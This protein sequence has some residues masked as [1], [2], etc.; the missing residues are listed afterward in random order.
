MMGQG[1]M[2]P[3]PGC[4]SLICRIALFG[5][6]ALLA[7]PAA[8]DQPPST[9]ALLTV[10]S[11]HFGKFE[12]LAFDVADDSPQQ[13]GP[14][15]ADDIREPA[16]SPDG[17]RLA[18]TSFRAGNADIW[19]VQADG[20]GLINI[21]ADPGADRHPC[22][23]P[24]GSQL[25]FCSNRSGDDEVWVTEIAGKMLVNISRN[26][27]VDWFPAWGSDLTK[28]AFMSNR[29][30]GSNGPKRLV[31]GDSR[32]SAPRDLLG[33]DL[34]YWGTPAWS[35]DGAMLVFAKFVPAVGEQIFV[36]DANGQKVRQL[37]TSTEY[38]GCFPAWSPDGRYIA[39][40][41]GSVEKT[42]ETQTNSDLMLLDVLLEKHTLL[43]KQTIMPYANGRPAWKLRHLAARQKN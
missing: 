6:V 14:V 19:I 9:A 3:R 32:G 29:L 8:A 38:W 12:L 41:R 37:T 20:Q 40:I 11:N 27:A 17:T 43:S 39:Y 21:T 18:F 31:V 28:I 30:A 34:H 24:D 26:P 13:L 7:T 33:Q 35:P 23:S 5:A 25:A 36:A 2:C 15:F 4:N 10:V 16:W 42:S 22:W 1:I